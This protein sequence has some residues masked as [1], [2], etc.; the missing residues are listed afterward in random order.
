MLRALT[1]ILACVCVWLCLASAGCSGTVEPSQGSDDP[2]APGGACN[3]E[4]KSVTGLTQVHVPVCSAT[5]Y[6]DN[7]P[8]GGNHYPQW[9]AYG[10]YAFAVPRGFWVHDLEHGGVV[11]TYNCPD[12]CAEDV[13]QVQA[14]IDALPEDCGGERRIVLTPDPLLDVRWGISA[15]GHTLRADCVDEARFRNFYLSHF[16]HAP[17][18]ICSGGTDFSGVAPCE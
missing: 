11:Y 4:L 16:G 2:A 9:A 8:A 17:E 10:T 12:G 5:D 1:P 14:L 3:V 18:Q 15:W 7:P 6:P 13:A